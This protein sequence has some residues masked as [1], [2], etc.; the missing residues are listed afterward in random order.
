M[1]EHSGVEDRPRI[2]VVGSSNTDLIVRAPTIPAPGETVLG[3]SFMTAAGGKGAN[4]AVA[5][6]RL[7][8]SVTFV[9]R[10]GMDDFGDAAVAALERESIDVRWVERDAEAASGVAFIVVND[11]GENAIAVAPGA[12]A[13]VDESQVDRAVE[14]IRDADILLLQLEIPLKVV[15]HATEIAREAGTMVILNPAPATPLGSELLA[16]VDV[17]TPNQG[18]AAMLSGRAVGGLEEAR[19][20]ARALRAAGPREVVVTLGTD[21]A[22]VEGADEQVHVPGVPVQAVDST[23]AGDAFSAAL[24]VGLARG[25]S[26]GDAARYATRV[27]ALTVTRAGAQPSLP[28]TEEVEA[29]DPKLR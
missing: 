24:A 6:A 29:F 25:G 14:A 9:G 12:N 16:A 4:Q 13:R 22:L 5:A 21:G 3:T 2:V 15:R 8:A 17:L 7:G 1:S 27:A 23:A 11:G 20:A 10:V 18:E 26:T 28:T 19:V